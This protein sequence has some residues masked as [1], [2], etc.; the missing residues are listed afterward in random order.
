[1]CRQ[2]EA[3]LC[4]FLHG[5]GFGGLKCE[6]L[7]AEW[8]TGLKSLDFE[9]TYFCCVSNEFLGL[10]FKFYHSKRPLQV[11]LHL[12]VV[13]ISQLWSQEL[14]KRLPLAIELLILF[15]INLSSFLFFSF[16]THFKFDC[17]STS[18]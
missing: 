17:D 8:L 12:W 3:L 2:D 1:M 15:F 14:S 4:S 16:A 10:S 9:H 11:V 18:K 6:V 13:Q 5:S 7:R